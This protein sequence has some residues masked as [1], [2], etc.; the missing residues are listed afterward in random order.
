MDRKIR[1]PRGASAASSLS[2]GFRKS[3]RLDVWRSCA[4]S[5]DGAANDAIIEDGIAARAI[6]ADDVASVTGRSAA[7]GRGL[8]TN[9]LDQPAATGKRIHTVGPKR[10]S[11][12][13]DCSWAAVVAP[14]DDRRPVG[15]GSSYRATAAVASFFSRPARASP[16]RASRR[17][18]DPVSR[19]EPH[20]FSLAPHLP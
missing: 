19:E 16:I 8:P 6:G 12:A 15:G 20:V 7:V 11:V 17:R 9:D 2:S 10:G 13:S 3:G 1:T 18:D 14:L 4:A 5:G